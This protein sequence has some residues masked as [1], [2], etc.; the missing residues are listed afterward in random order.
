MN[1][2][3][4]AALGT[5]PSFLFVSDELSYANLPYIHEILNHT[6]TILGSIALIQVIQPV[7]RKAV[8]AEAVSELTLH[9]P[10]AV[11]DQTRDAGF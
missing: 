6:H 5:G 9:Y 7:T 10:L 2:N 3:Y 1:T 11:F 8:T 4:P